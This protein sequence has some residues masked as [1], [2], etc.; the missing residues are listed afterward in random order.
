MSTQEHTHTEEEQLGKSY[1]G[2]LMRRLLQY[3]KPYKRKVLLA[4][5]LLLVTSL[6]AL[7]QPL[8]TQYAIDHYILAGNYS[9]LVLIT[10]L[11]CGAFGD[12]FC[13]RV[14]AFLHHANDRSIH[15]V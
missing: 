12:Q 8:I 14:F 13:F 6:F 11:F 5:G 7:T 3:L 4:A 1:D 2:R 10:A 15:Y 9:G